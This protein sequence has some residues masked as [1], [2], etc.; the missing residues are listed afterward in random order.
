MTGGIR[1]EWDVLKHINGVVIDGDRV[2]YDAAYAIAQAG[3]A[4]ASAYAN[5]RQYVDVVDLADY[6][7]V[8]LFCATSEVFDSDLKPGENLKKLLL[9]Y[10]EEL[11]LGELPTPGPL[12]GPADAQLDVLIDEHAAG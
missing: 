4:S 11:G 10:H 2:A 12:F 9:G 5:L 1:S 6:L 7:I 8:N 3:V